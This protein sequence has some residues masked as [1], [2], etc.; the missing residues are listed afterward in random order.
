MKISIDYILF[1]EPLL[2]VIGS[3]ILLVH[4]SS[5]PLYYQFISNMNIVSHSFMTKGLG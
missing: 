4:T 3:V 5:S 1:C 2:F